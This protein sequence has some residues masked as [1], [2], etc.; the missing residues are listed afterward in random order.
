[1]P[2]LVCMESHDEVLEGRGGGIGRSGTI[3][4]VEELIVHG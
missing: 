1:M 2:D 3:V 4:T